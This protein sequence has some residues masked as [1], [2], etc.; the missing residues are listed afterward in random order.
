MDMDSQSLEIIAIIFLILRI[1][2]VLQLVNSMP[3]A[4]LR[5]NNSNFLTV[6]VFLK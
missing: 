6:F 4:A 2:F 1:L 3:L 5:S